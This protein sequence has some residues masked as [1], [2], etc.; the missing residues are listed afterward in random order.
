MRGCLGVLVE[1]HGLCG[2]HLRQCAQPMNYDLIIFAC[3]VDSC[4]KAKACSFGTMSEVQ[5]FHGRSEQG[6]LHCSQAHPD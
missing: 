5:R 4:R 3:F 6:Q 1:Y 2:L